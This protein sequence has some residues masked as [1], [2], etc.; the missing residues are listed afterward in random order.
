MILPS[1]ST[2]AFGKLPLHC[3]CKNTAEVL[4]MGI[5][6]RMYLSIMKNIMKGATKVQLIGF[7][8]LITK[9]DLASRK[10]GI[11]ITIGGVKER[12]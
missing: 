10:T 9:T 4:R 2:T 7:S 1:F 8:I 12:Q 5:M 3:C 6:F 11:L